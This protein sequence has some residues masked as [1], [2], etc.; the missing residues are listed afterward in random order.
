MV[1]DVGVGDESSEAANGGAEV[2]PEVVIGARVG[3]VGVGEDSTGA[4]NGGVEDG[5]EV[6]IVARAELGVSS[7]GVGGEK[8][9]LGAGAGAEW[10]GVLTGCIVVNCWGSARR[11]NNSAT[12]EVVGVGVWLGGGGGV[13]R[14]GGT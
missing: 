12:G 5:P 3:D 6:V 4:A 2:G 8:M 14:G 7:G 11:R 10:S 1:G 13:R 9:A